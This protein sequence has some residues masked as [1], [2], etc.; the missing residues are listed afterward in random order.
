MNK[1]VKWK[2]GIPRINKEFGLKGVMVT[3]Y[4][5]KMARKFPTT[6]TNSNGY[7]LFSNLSRGNY[8]LSFRNIPSECKFTIKDAISDD[9]KD[10]DADKNGDNPWIYNWIVAFYQMMLELCVKVVK[11]I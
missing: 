8:Y 11:R 7:Y 5:L 9:T 3:S 4:L 1:M 2:M 6:T 10:S